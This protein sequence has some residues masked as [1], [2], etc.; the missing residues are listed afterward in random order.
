MS[1]RSEIAPQRVPSDT[2]GGECGGGVTEATDGGARFKTLRNS[3]VLSL[4]VI[5]EKLG[6]HF[7]NDMLQILGDDYFDLGKFK[8]SVR[9]SWDCSRISESL[10]KEANKETRGSRKKS[11][12]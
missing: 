6:P 7:V 1:Q 4:C 9:T 3:L 8:E 10:L 5:N 2:A 12:K 11:T